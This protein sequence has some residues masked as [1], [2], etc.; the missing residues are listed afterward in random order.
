MI[1][2]IN[3]TD[4][5][6]SVHFYAAC[7]NYGIGCTDSRGIDLC[8]IKVFNTR[9]ER[10]AYVECNGFR[11]GH[12]FAECV[13]SAYARRVMQRVVI[14]TFGEQLDAVNDLP[15]FVGRVRRMSMVEL[16]SNYLMICA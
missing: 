14:A 12:S 5:T 1:N 8:Y 3:I 10:D 13:D 6:R 11:D 7:W 9:V 2:N 15:E 16:V 4:G